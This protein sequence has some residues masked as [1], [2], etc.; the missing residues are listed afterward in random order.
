[1]TNE[2]KT[3]GKGASTPETTEPLQLHICIPEELTPAVY[4]N[5]ISI[6]RTPGEFV[7]TF[8]QIPPLRDEIDRQEV[9]NRGRLDAVAVANVIIADQFVPRILDIL[10]KLRETTTMKEAVKEGNE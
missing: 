1:M 7:L 6:S 8:A 4:A 2:A 9:H 5:H 10:S 3:Q